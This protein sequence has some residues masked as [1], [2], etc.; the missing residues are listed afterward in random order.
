MAT[1]L[2]VG[3]GLLIRTVVGMLN[4]PLGFE[5]DRLMTARMALP[6]PNDLARA[7]YADPARRVASYHEALGR[8]GALPGVERAAM[9]SQ[10]PMGGFNPP[11]FVELTRDSGD[12]A[13]RPVVHD[14]QVSAGYFDT[15][16]TRIVRGRAFSESDRAGAPVAIVSET[17]ARMF[18][19]GRDPLGERLRFSPELP[20]MTVVGVAGDVM[21]RRLT[22]PPQPI[23]YRPFEQSPGFAMALLVRARAATPGLGESLARAVREVDPNLPLHSVR[24][25]NEVIE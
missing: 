7:T 9:S 18:W 16:G 4:V 25:M 19:K 22:E 24:T 10:I 21:N 1:V 15:I 5:T 12:G 20:W 17:A 2:L 11:L 3:A 23:L 6:R 13:P 14:F 8:I